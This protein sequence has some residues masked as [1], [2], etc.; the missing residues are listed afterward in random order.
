MPQPLIDYGAYWRARPSVYEK[1]RREATPWIAPFMEGVKGET[2]L[3]SVCIHSGVTSLDHLQEFEDEFYTLPSAGKK[4]TKIVADRFW[5]KGVVWLPK[6]LPTKRYDPFKEEIFEQA[7]FRR[8][9][10]VGNDPIYEIRKQAAQEAL[11]Q[12]R[13]ID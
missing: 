9:K 2:Q 7:F 8:L 5:K 4:L 11:R 12:M 10:V 6:I 1:A 3:R 13:T